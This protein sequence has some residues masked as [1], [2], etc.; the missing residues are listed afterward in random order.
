MKK[1]LM[2]GVALAALVAVP[3]MAADL[4][5]PAPVYKAPPMPVATFSW[6]GCYLGGNIGYGWGK[7]STD[8]GSV[9]N[10]IVDEPQADY[11]SSP[12]GRDWWW[13]DRLQLSV[14]V[15]RHRP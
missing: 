3:A 13:S 1:V 9:V 14:R 12:V 7:S 11:G 15:V 6:T 8:A 4:G 2:T 10:P 5:R